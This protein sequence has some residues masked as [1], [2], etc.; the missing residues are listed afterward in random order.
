MKTS[1]RLWT[2]N[3]A[4]C[5]AAVLAVATL[6]GCGSGSGST[7][8]GS[9]GTLGVS[10][11]GTTAGASV[12]DSSATSIAVSNGSSSYPSACGFDAVN[13]T[14]NKVR[15]HA[16]SSASENDAGWTDILVNRKINLLALG[17][18]ALE[19]LG[20]VPLLPGSYT[21]LRLVLDPNNGQGL[22]N[23]VVPTGGVET[24]LVTPSA[25][26]SGIKLV[27]QFTVVAGQRADTVLDFDVC[28]SIVRRGNGSYGLKP[29]I[30]VTPYV[31]SGIDGFV[32][33]SA[34][35]SGVTVSAQQNGTVVRST[36]PTS[37]GE[38]FLGRL[39]VGYYDVV[40]TANGRTTAVIA[41]VP[42][43]TTTSVA[44]L[45]TTGA[46]LVLPTSDTNSISGAATLN[47]TSTS[48]MAYVQ[49]LQAV[50]T[51]TPVVSVAFTF[52]DNTSLPPGAYALT[53]PVA[54]P[55]LG[56]FSLSL[57]IGLVAQ[58]ASQG[59]YSVQASASGYQSQ[60]VDLDISGGSVTQDFV[61][62]P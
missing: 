58:T 21:Q 60:T 6:A 19:E 36:T 11:T 16:S 4:L 38:F 26:Q 62:V 46:P 59:K 2:A 28:R 54:A 53:L 61:L 33:T 50:G 15:I 57:P 55:L 44:V 41:G 22:S 20:Q 7:S 18:G 9:T 45:S 23:S 17:N 51:T 3:W 56:Q 25:V 40:M 13:V 10:L 5:I 48:E 14:V 43:A 39:P 47:P 52:A 30:Q 24:A 49:A 35:G 27:G 29:V 34:L 8:A 12:S 37:T 1:S 32:D 31:L 42:I